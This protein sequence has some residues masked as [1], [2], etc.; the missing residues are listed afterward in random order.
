MAPGFPQKNTQKTN[1]PN[2]QP[3]TVD[4]NRTGPMTYKCIFDKGSFTYVV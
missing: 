2:N 4:R 1:Q 3:E